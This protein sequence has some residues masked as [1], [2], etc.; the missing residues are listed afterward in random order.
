ML[1]TEDGNKRGLAGNK[2][3]VAVLYSPFTYQMKI[4]DSRLQQNISKKEIAFVY[5]GQML[6]LFIVS[7]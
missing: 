6:F 3:S 7:V 1:I 4:S 5:N 2:S